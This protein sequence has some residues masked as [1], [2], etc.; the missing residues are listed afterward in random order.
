MV[1]EEGC[2]RCLRKHVELEMKLAVL[3]LLSVAAARLSASAVVEVDREGSTC[4]VVEVLAPKKLLLGLVPATAAVGIGEMLDLALA[5]L[6]PKQLP[7]G[8]VPVTGTIGGE[9]LS[10]VATRS[11]ETRR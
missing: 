9:A 10:G 7:L 3:P 1:E 2:W 8:L 6:A 4:A 5:P 11:R